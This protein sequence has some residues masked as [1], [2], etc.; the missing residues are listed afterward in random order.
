[1]QITMRKLCLIIPFCLLFLPG[2]GQYIGDTVTIYIDNRMELKIALEDY[3]KLGETQALATLRAF[4]QVL[5]AA[6][7]RISAQGPDKL[8]FDKDGE[9]TIAPGNPAIVF[10]LNGAQAINSGTRDEVFLSGPDVVMTITATD[11]MLASSTSVAECLEKVIQQLPRKRSWAKSLYFE[12][13]D[14]QV[15]S[16]DALEETHE[17]DFLEFTPGVGFGLVKNEWVTDVGMK[18]GLG[19]NYKGLM[20]HN[21]YVSANVVFNFDSERKISTNTFLNLGYRWNVDRKGAKPEML[22]VEFGFLVDKN[23]DLFDDNTFRFGMNWMPTG[24][25]S[26]SPQLYFGNNFKEFYPGIRI[27]LGF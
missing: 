8:T 17:L 14:G 10:Q 15:T 16:L 5:P 9:L 13:I 11:I 24:A 2:F 12:C 18:I 27:G 6:S 4:E 23:G 25:V 3:S 20:R 1:M 22:G 21:P 19:F 7:S 26:V